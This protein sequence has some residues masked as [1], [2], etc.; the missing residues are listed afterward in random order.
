LDDSAVDWSAIA[1]ASNAVHAK[2]DLS[3]LT[4]NVVR[5]ARDKLNFTPDGST[6]VA[7]LFDRGL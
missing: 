2:M 3:Q 1:A 6:G 4:Q 5:F 7:A